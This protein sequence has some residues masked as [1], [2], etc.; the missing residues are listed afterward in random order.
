MFNSEKADQGETITKFI[1]IYIVWYKKLSKG[2]KHAKRTEEIQK[3]A[4]GLEMHAENVKKKALT[5]WA[6]RQRYR[7]CLGN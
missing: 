6:R 2:S 7:F 5:I 4:R 3:T 1:Q